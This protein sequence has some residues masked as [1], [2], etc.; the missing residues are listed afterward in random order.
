[1]RVMKAR[2]GLAGLCVLWA[3]CGGAAGGS[4]GPSGP[5]ASP[6][7]GSAQPLAVGLLV[8][9]RGS[10][11]ILRYDGSGASGGVFASDP[12]LVR[13]VGIT[14]G[15]DGN[16]YVAAG[17]TDRVLKLS[18][19]TGASLGVFAHGATIR[20]PRNVNFGPD[21]AFY[22][23]DGFLGQI[24]RFD[25]ATGDFDRVFI[26]DP[27]LQ[28]PTSFT[29]GPDGDV[30]VVSVLTNR[31]LRFEGT[32]GALLG[33]FATSN[34]QQPHDVS[35]GPDANLYVTNSGS[36]VIQRFRGDTGEYIGPFV[37]DPAL[38]QPLG[39]AWGPDGN[40]YVANQGANEI[41]R[42]DGA[43][44]ASLGALVAPGAGGLSAPSFFVFLKT[45][46]LTLSGAPDTARGAASLRVSGAQPGARILIAHG[47]TGGAGGVGE[48]PGLQ[49]GVGAPV[50]DQAR[51]ADESGNTV[52]ALAGPR[53]ATVTFVAVDAARCTATAPVAVTLP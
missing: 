40:L 39:M 16:L 45:P 33:P 14:F 41:R 35:F 51:V 27:T 10:D 48:C 20:S 4:S 3:A 32:T 37:T 9:S 31:V 15:P 38:R 19:T 2:T 29:F 18:G 11:L 17:D 6:T 22:V 1:M 26:Q 44:G 12:A 49:V 23:A 30:Y 43:T 25:G 36:T 28:G 21:G 42:Y 34:L 47:A 46:G 7:P 50:V 8:S 52:A 5:A 24:L 13:P 53:G